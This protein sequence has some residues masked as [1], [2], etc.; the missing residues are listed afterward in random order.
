MIKSWWEDKP[1]REKCFLI[2]LGTLCTG[3]FI[4]Y[5]I[6]KPVDNL[7]NSQQMQLQKMQRDLVWMQEQANAHG[8]LRQPPLAQPLEK[9]VLDEAKQA[10]LSILLDS[11]NNESL[12][13]KPT[14]LPLENL[15]QWLNALQY[16]HGIVIDEL[17][18]AI[19]P[20]TETHINVERLVLRSPS[21]VK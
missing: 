19:D 21:L 15:S 10:R 9:T 17:Q 1:P 2:V 20:K 6:V 18:F 16:T 7:I 4:S 14:T 12:V 5:G 8:L 11:S 3:V 13:I